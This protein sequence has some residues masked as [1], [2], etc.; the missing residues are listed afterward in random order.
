[1]RR[2]KEEGVGGACGG[3]GA[4]RARASLAFAVSRFFASRDPF[5]VVFDLGTRYKH[6]QTDPL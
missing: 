6:I 4:A 1:V 2:R 5:F 3:V